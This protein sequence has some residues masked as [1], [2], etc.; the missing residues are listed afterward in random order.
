MFV[1]SE[2]MFTVAL[3][4]F[5]YGYFVPRTTTMMAM[6][7][8][9]QP[10][11]Q[12]TATGWRIF[13]QWVMF[14]HARLG[15]VWSLAS[16]CTDRRSQLPNNLLCTVISASCTLD[17]FWVARVSGTRS[18]IVFFALCSWGARACRSFW[19]LFAARKIQVCLIFYRDF[20]LLAII[21]FELRC[22]LLL[23]LLSS[24]ESI[25]QFVIAG[26]NVFIFVG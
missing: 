26:R 14:D 25:C 5:N 18:R 8:V 21:P 13:G 24:V 9:R 4:C 20:F 7:T 23:S 6:T 16:R 1:L 11:R 17:A 12:G 3:Y 22:V 2:P 10:I 15:S 19:S